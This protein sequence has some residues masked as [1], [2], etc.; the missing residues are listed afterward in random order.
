MPFDG[1]SHKMMGLIAHPGEISSLSVSGDGNY[2]ITAGGRDLTVNVWKI[3][4][5]AVQVTERAIIVPC[6]QENHVSTSKQRQTL[7]RNK[8][9]DHLYHLSTRCCAIVLKLPESK[10]VLSWRFQS[11]LFQLAPQPV[12]ASTLKP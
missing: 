7:G 6:A 5:Q 4:T 8:R 1:N 10:H 2:L 11:P 12:T 9:V 3:N